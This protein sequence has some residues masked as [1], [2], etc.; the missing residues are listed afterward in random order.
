MNP[1]FTPVKNPA[2]L[3]VVIRR[4]QLPSADFDGDS[5]SIP[6]RT[7][8]R[9]RL[10]AFART[11]YPAIVV[12]ARAY[13]DITNNPAFIRAVHIAHKKKRLKNQRRRRKTKAMRKK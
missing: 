1:Q 5:P 9:D 6:F 2:L 13:R 4:P 12:I 3:P 10:V 8:Y 7:S 11:L